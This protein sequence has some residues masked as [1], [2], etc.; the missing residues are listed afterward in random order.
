MNPH[1][2]LSPIMINRFGLDHLATLDFSADCRFYNRIT[3]KDDERLTTGII[4]K[5][6]V[7]TFSVP[8]GIMNANKRMALSKYLKSISI[9]SINNNVIMKIPDNVCFFSMHDEFNVERLASMAFHEHP[10]FKNIITYLHGNIISSGVIVGQTVFANGYDIRIT[11]PRQG[12]KFFNG[13]SCQSASFSLEHIKNHNSLRIREL[14][15]G[16]G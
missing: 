1:I 5:N 8:L 6:M 3:I 4:F 13:Q 11:P 7:Y 15:H 10:F 2:K 12:S 9:D 14:A 16:I